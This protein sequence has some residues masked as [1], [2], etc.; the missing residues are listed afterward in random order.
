MINRKFFFDTVR[1]SLFGGR[2][3]AKQV[4]GL[5][6][7]LNEWESGCHTDDRHLAYMLATAYHEVDKTMIPI[8]EYGKTDY[9][10]KRYGPGTAVGK[11]LGNTQ[12][13]DGARY[14]GRGLVQLTG[15]ANYERMG[16]LLGV[17]LITNPDLAYLRADVAV[18]IMFTGMEQG[19]FTGKK[20]SD[21][22]NSTDED[23]I[24][25]RKIIN[26]RDKASLIA[27]Y[28]KKFY[29]ALSHRA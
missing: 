7:I 11:K 16:K 23:W 9:F 15:R 27:E 2:L 4:E 14:A 28:A 20:L 17:D 24:G 21:S 1:H 26:G 25:A 10:N 22:F 18:K 3:A 8:H 12:P 6:S 5:S 29:A 13:G 19:L